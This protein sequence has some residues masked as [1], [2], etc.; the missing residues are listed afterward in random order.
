MIE[1]KEDRSLRKLSYYSSCNSLSQIRRDV[2]TSDHC[3][4]ILPT[5]MITEKYVDTS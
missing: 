1:D 2:Q 4:V 3:D 5:H